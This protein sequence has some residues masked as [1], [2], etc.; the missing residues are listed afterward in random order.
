VSD[1]FMR[2]W[3]AVAVVASAILIAFFPDRQDE[4]T[5]DLRQS[6]SDL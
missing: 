5:R 1:D 6:L 4:A 2:T 3:K